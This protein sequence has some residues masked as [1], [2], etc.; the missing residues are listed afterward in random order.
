MLSGLGTWVSDI[1][2]GWGWDVVGLDGQLW[3]VSERVPVGAG[4]SAHTVAVFL[5]HTSGSRPQTTRTNPRL[6]L[7][8]FIEHLKRIC[9][10][11]M[12]PR[13]PQAY[14]CP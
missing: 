5:P 12:V 4:C 9:N 8:K 7:H 1:E 6:Q 2:V 13:T 10:V 11:A 3:R 14:T